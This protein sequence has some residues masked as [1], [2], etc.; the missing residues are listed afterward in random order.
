MK[1]TIINPADSQKGIMGIEQRNGAV[2]RLIPST[3]RLSAA[4]RYFA[5][6]SVYDIACMHGISVRQVYTSAWR[7]V[8]TVNKTFKITFPKTKSK[9]EYI[10]TGFKLKSKAG[11][12]GCVGC[13]DGMLLWTDR[14]TEKEAEK[15]GIGSKK[16]Y[17]GR[18][19]KYGLIM[20]GCVDHERRFTDVDIKHPGA[21]SDYLAFAMSNLKSR[22]EGGLLHDD[23]YLFGDCA[24]S[25]TTYMVTPFKNTGGDD[26]LDA[27]NYYHSQLRIN[28]ECAFGMLVNRW[29]ILRRPLPSSM[30]IHKQTALTVCLCK[31]HNF[32]IEERLEEALSD[33]VL[34][35][36]KRGGCVELRQ[37]ENDDVVP[38]ELLNDEHH[39]D[40]SPQEVRRERDRERRQRAILP[41]TELFESI[42][43]QRLRRPTPRRWL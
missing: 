40:I 30:C 37:N 24:Y 36:Y 31:L 33:D 7:V 16:F 18:K 3:I 11:F 23:K 8:D 5:G 2:N 32:L 15:A 38:V 21:T 19:K 22:L 41:R 1:Y 25:N 6:G 42:V 14:P 27:F 35:C 43:T 12:D 9:Q 29:S 10:A 34:E 13:V 4:I 39:D 20:T 17:C 28:V 26:E